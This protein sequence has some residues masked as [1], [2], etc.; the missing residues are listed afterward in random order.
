MPRFRVTVIR[1][2]SDL[3][4]CMIDVEADTAEAAVEKVKGMNS[5][6]WD[7]NWWQSVDNDA[8]DQYEPRELGPDEDFYP[9]P[10]GNE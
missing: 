2:V 1:E 4:R 9:E 6:E 10:E 8:P 3:T 7:F 5:D